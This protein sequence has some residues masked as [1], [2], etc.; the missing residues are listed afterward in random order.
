MIVDCHT[1]INQDE[2][3][4]FKE[5]LVEEKLQGIVSNTTVEEYLQNKN[6]LNDEIENNKV[7]LSFGVH[8]WDADIFNP[9][10]FIEI[11]E[12]VEVIGEIGLDNK[13]CKVP[14]DI[15]ERVFVRQLEIAESLKKPV[16]IHTTGAEKRVLEIIKNFKMKKL[17]HWY[18]DDKYL[19][20]YIKEDCFFSIN[21]SYELNAVEQVVAERV[22]LERIL[23][24]TDGTESLKWIG[25]GYLQ[26]Q[27]GFEDITLDE[28][29]YLLKESLEY[30]AETKDI[31]IKV[32]E[33][34]LYENY[35]NLLGGNF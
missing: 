15:Q 5:L 34:K 24:E 35:R 7:K 6:F 25:D 8:P 18:E 20:E 13:W 3:G 31:D 2:L 29:L 17:I 19:D 10:D 16:T 9:D 4:K 21:P 22:P 26:F 23:L 30:I 27:Y 33:D 14:K 28:S 11:Y 12:E 1:H 32:C